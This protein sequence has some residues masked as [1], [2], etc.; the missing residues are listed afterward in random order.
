MIW[1]GFA[2]SL[3]AALVISR[4][5][6]ALGLI[7]G[8]AVLGLFT[9]P[10]E[11]LLRAVADTLTDPSIL[12]ITAAMG[13]IPLLGGTMKESGQVES[14]VNNLRIKQRHLMTLSAAIMGLLPMPGGALLSAPILDKGG[15]GVENV[16]KS[17]I[18]N[19]FRHIFLLVYPLCPALIVSAKITGLDV[20]HAIMYLL[21]VFVLAVI[22]GYYFFLRH[23]NGQMVYHDRFSLSGLTI[24]LAIVM[25]A[26]VLDFSLK[27][28]FGLGA[29]ATLMGV[30]T[31]I[32][33]SVFVSRQKL[34]I[35][36]IIT[37]TRP[38][39]FSSIIIGMFLYLRVFEQSDA[40]RAIAS[41][42]LPPVVTATA[43]GFV[44][45]FVT[46]GVQLPASIVFPVYLTAVGEVTPIMFALIYATTY[47]GYNISPIHPCL[48]VTCEYFRVPVRTVIMRSLT[49]TL[50]ILV[51]IAVV[52]LL[53]T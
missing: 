35:R 32:A 13:I 20:Y 5:N 43:G 2:A 51:V 31:A 24:P 7:V 42:P 53:V 10:V 16:R 19:W 8:S 6:L 1:I 38:W 27:R 9:L 52:T 23:V 46:G 39:F 40:G 28:L 11:V 22:L 17:A 15:V 12:M 33:L 30:C 25:C 26:P 37:Q 3:A 14:L 49:P 48:V 45:A 41:L 21:P 36:R 47:F 4:K 34:D 44:L 29:A 50:I 18:N